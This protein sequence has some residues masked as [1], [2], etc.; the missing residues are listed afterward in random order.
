MKPAI[1]PHNGPSRGAVRAENIMPDNVITAGVP[2]I[3]Y[4]GIRES[5]SIKAVHT[6]A[7]AKNSELVT[8]FCANH[9]PANVV[10]FIAV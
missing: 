6:A 10:M 1:V 2:K 4:A 9:D 7:N 8:Y 3:G 5:A